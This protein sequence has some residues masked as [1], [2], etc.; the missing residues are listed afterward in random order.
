MSALGRSVAIDVKTEASLANRPDHKMRKMGL[1][2]RPERIAVLDHAFMPK[3]C[4]F[5]SHTV[6][7]GFNDVD[8]EGGHMAPRLAWSDVTKSHNCPVSIRIVWPFSPVE[9]APRGQ[10]DII[11]RRLPSVLEEELDAGAVLCDK[12]ATNGHQIGPQL[13]FCCHSLNA[14][15]LE[16]DGDGGENTNCGSK[17]DKSWKPSC[18]F[19]REHRRGNGQEKKAAEKTGCHRHGNVAEIAPFVHGRLSSTAVPFFARAA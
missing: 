6:A 9:L 2:L 16:H 14:H 4:L 15:S 18:A 3:E 5:G 13:A 8:F 10:D 11:R 7:G 19:G 12:V 17:P 1:T